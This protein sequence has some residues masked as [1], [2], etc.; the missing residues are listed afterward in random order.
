M[1]SQDINKY[2]ELSTTKVTDYDDDLKQ[3]NPYF[4]DVTLVGMGESTHGTHE[5]FTMRHRMFKYL[6]EHHQ[7]TTFFL[8]ADYANC[9]RANTYIHGKDDVAIE[10][11]K[12]IGLWPWMTYEM[13]DLINW[14]RT[15]NQENPDK[16]LSFIGVDMQK[17]K[18]TITQMDH[19]LRRYNLSTTDSITCQKIL[20]SNIH[21]INKPDELEIYKTTWEEKKTIDIKLLEE[22][23]KKI[24]TTLLRHLTQI[25]NQ[26]FKWEK[27]YDY[28]DICMAENILFHLEENTSIKGFFWAHNAH[29]SKRLYKEGKKKEWKSAGGRLKQKIGS[30]YFAIAQDFDKGTFN[31][32]YPDSNSTDIKEGKAYTLGPVTVDSFTKGSFITEYGDLKNPLFIDC[33]YLP[34]KKYMKISHIDAL[35]Y[36][37]KKGNQKSEGSKYYHTKSELDAIILIKITTATQLL[38]GVA[39]ND[40][41]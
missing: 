37:G 33:S 40:K 11:V 22:K 34:K 27:K 2:I 9:L 20:N 41:E 18:E 29:M 35:Y 5:F 10:I 38:K 13:V 32:Y 26:K 21:T 16:K 3:L 24:Y 19:I 39:T 17:Y 8:E 4:K 31:S 7:F 25:I 15:Y 1:N 23:D 14:M 28:R 6:V 12:E 36:P 30:Q